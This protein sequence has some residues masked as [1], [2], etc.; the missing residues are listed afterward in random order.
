MIFEVTISSQLAILSK[1]PHK[2]I[3]TSCSTPLL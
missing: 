3:K 2:Q 1:K